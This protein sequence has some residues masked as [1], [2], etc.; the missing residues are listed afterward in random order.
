M[1]ERPIEGATA[2][3]AVPAATTTHPAR[4]RRWMLWILAVVVIVPLLLI[5]AWTAIALAWTYSSGDRAGYI[6]K[7]SQKGWVCKTWEGDLAMST[8]PGSA[9]ERFAFTVRDDSV[10]QAITKLMGSRVAV[11]YEQ[12]RGVPGSCFGETEYFVTGVKPVA[13]P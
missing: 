12:H 10:A 8:I 11:H 6:Q 9:P 3:R 5:G 13:G 2:E 7:F 4:K 1:D